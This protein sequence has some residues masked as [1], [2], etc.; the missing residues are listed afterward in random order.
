MTGSASPRPVHREKD[1]WARFDATGSGQGQAEADRLNARLGGWAYQLG[2]WQ[3]KALAPTLD[4]LKA[5]APEKSCQL[6]RRAAQA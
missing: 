4:D 1:L 6:R 5:P 2:S 3:E